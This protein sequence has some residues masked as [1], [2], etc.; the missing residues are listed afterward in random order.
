[1]ADDF[2]PFSISLRPVPTDATAE[3]AR[4]GSHQAHIDAAVDRCVELIATDV[5]LARAATAEAFEAAVAPMLTALAREVLARELAAAPADIE[6]LARAALERFAAES[7]IGLILS[8][9]DAA[10]VRLD[11]PIRVD[12]TLESGDIALEVR[13][14]IVDSRVAVRLGGALEAALG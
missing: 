3:A 12:P 14:G 4:E 10:R 6:K 9:A 11:L 2:I 7:P 1:M 8:P 5:A 13:D